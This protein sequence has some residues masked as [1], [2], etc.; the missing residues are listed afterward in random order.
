MPTKGE[1]IERGSAERAALHEIMAA[2]ADA[3]A[4]EAGRKE[5]YGLTA[6]ETAAKIAEAKDMFEARRAEECKAA[7]GECCACEFWTGDRVDGRIATLPN[8]LP[9]CDSRNGYAVALRTV[10]D[11]ENTVLKTRA[12]IERQKGDVQR[13]ELYLAEAK[14]DLKKMEADLKRETAR[15]AASTRNVA[16]IEAGMAR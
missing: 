7:C 16:A 1:A 12:M 11:A 6:D 13:L 2:Y 4:V 10:E 8:G 5:Y 14:D 9:V 15:V 3:L